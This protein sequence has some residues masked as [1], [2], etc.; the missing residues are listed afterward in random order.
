MS[1]FEE[2]EEISLSDDSTKHSDQ[3]PV[4]RKINSP[5]PEKLLATRLT[6]LKSNPNTFDAESL[7]AQVK[8]PLK[9][10][11]ISPPVVE[12]ML[13]SHQLTLN[14]KQFLKQE[15]EYL[16]LKQCSFTP[17][18]KNHSR[19][20]S[21]KEFYDQEIKFVNKKE[22]NLSTL[23]ASKSKKIIEDE[24]SSMDRIK[25]SS[26]SKRILNRVK[27]ASELEIITSR[28]NQSLMHKTI[29]ISQGIVKS[30]GKPPLPK[31]V[32]TPPLLKHK[33]C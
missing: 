14:R 20:R 16:E 31:P 18:I 4:I 1:I 30:L 23:R 11:S 27:K 6:N 28:S 2:Y 25:I 21:F 22:E 5:T 13:F 12:R 19:K 10:S 33:P 7:L 32:T 15:K 8:R 24:K 3:A 9:F 17:K 29:S 26:G